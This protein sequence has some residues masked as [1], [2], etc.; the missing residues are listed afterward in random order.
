MYPTFPEDFQTPLT[1]KKI[2]V[3]K[4]KDKQYK[5]ADGQNLFLLVTPFGNK[6][7]RFHYF[8]E[9]KENTPGIGLYPQM[10]LKEALTKRDELNMIIRNGIKPYTDKKKSWPNKNFLRWNLKIHSGILR[11]NGLKR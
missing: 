8:F 10:S 9:R 1:I 2:E 11:L 7:W 6:L 4:P 3:L 5:K